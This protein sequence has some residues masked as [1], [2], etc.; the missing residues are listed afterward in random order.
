MRGRSVTPRA[1][2]PACHVRHRPTTVPGVGRGGAA[3][4]TLGFPPVSRRSASR[5]PVAW[6]GPAAGPELAWARSAAAECAAVVDFA[7]VAAAVASGPGAPWPALV[8]LGCDVPARWTVADL[9]ALARRWPLAPLV[10]VA[11]AIVA[12]RRRS[13]PA[14]PGVEEVP[15]SEVAA[16][17]AWW[18]ADRDAGRPGTLGLPATARREDR[19]LEAATSLRPSSGATARVSVAAGRQIDLDGIADLVAASGRTIVRRIC[20]RPPLDEPADVL[21]WDTDPLEPAHLAWLRMLAAN[22]PDLAIVVVDSFP[23]PDTALVALRSGAAAVLGRPLSPESLAGALVSLE[24]AAGTGLG[25]A[26]DHR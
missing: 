17:M 25:Q 9:T 1:S 21:L 15:W 18:L 4:F 11:P 22:R 2:C 16:R 7:D 10:S 3:A 14:L 20:G 23:T 5:D 26:P 19:A 24:S 13:G 8:L 6:V 12:G